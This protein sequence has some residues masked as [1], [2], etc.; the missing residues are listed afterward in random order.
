MTRNRGCNY[1]QV[2]DESRRR[3]RDQ[4][5]FALYRAA[6]LPA[7]SGRA[8]E[9]EFPASRGTFD[10]RIRGGGSAGRARDFAL[11]ILAPETLVILK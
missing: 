7:R 8:D 9:N 6:F 10:R 11:S 5:D 2:I 1:E 3:K 4:R